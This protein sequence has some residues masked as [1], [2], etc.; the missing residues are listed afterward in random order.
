MKAFL[1]PWVLLAIVGV[2]AGAFFFGMKVGSD[3]EV[4]AQAKFEARLKQ[5]QETAEAAAAK[6]IGEIQIVHKTIQTKTKETIREEPVYRDCV[7]VPAVER[8]LD[9]ARA[10]R[11]PSEPAGDS[12]VP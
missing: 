7:N 5:V 10:N 12:R 8:L 11:K 4:A 3:H 1:N 2:V 9:D 6:K